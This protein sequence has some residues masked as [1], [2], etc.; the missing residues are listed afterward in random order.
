M[1]ITLGEARALLSALCIVKPAIA[2]PAPTKYAAK[3]RG[4][5]TFSMIVLALSLSEKV[6][7]WLIGND[8]PANKEIINAITLI[9]R[10]TQIIFLSEIVIKVLICLIP[11]RIRLKLEIVLRQ[12]FHMILL[13]STQLIPS[14]H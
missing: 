3:N 14:W 10:P 5:R 4:I 7:C 2:R 9:I 13:Q 6:N 1:P 11:F 8:K 12:H